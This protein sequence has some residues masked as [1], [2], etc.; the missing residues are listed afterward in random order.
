MVR[1]RDWREVAAL[2]PQGLVQITYD[3][4]ER[5][6]GPIKEVRIEPDGR[7]FIVPKWLCEELHDRYGRLVGHWRV[8]NRVIQFDQDEA[9]WEAKTV[10]GV[11]VV[12]FH[13]E[14]VH[15]M[16]GELIDGVIEVEPSDRLD[17]AS[18]I[19][20]QLDENGCEPAPWWFEIP[21]L[22]GVSDVRLE[23]HYPDKR[24]VAVAEMPMT[25]VHMLF[26]GA[27]AYI[28][29]DNWPEGHGDQCNAEFKMR[30]ELAIESHLVAH[31]PN[32]D[33]TM[34]DTV[35]TA[36]R[37]LAE[38]W[39]GVTVEWTGWVNKPAGG[40]YGIHTVTLSS[41]LNSFAEGLPQN[42]CR[43][44]GFDHPSK[45]DEAEEKWTGNLRALGLYLEQQ[46]RQHFDRA[47]VE[48]HLAYRQV[49]MPQL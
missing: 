19:D 40:G 1:T 7:V 11:Q 43:L 39:G 12:E 24:G 8:P 47:A 3:G 45:L 26:Q 9:A 38:S 49:L 21:G 31:A 17:P 32:D 28:E 5:L 20:L 42:Q 22:V 29:P 46:I 16:S 44:L 14:I 2:K 41:L 4:R 34:P 25:W 13:G 36:L 23:H 18:V 30:F 6:L 35:A 27:K 15:L 48:A 33:K 37:G 10:S